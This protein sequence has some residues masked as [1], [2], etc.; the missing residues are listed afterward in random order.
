MKKYII[1]ILIGM[2]MLPGCASAGKAE[3]ADQEDS[4]EAG[5]ADLD[6]QLQ[7]ISDSSKLW[8]VDS[9]YEEYWYAVTDL[10]RDSS[11]EMIA[12]SMQGSGL[13]TWFSIYEVNEDR[14]GL[15]LLPDTL[16]QG[17]SGPDLIVDSA[18]TVEQDGIV[19]YYFEDVLRITAAEHRV[20]KETLSLE[21]DQVVIRPI[22]SFQT[23]PELDENGEPEADSTVEE[24]FDG[25][26]RKI[27]REEFDSLTIIPDGCETIGFG[28]T[29]LSDG[30]SVEALRESF[31]H[32]KLF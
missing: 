15:N 9:E 31:D 24:Y 7:L 20:T 30:I 22:A 25:A 3:E 5:R 10:D 26:N 19:Y 14:T 29:D 13:Y 28:W 17:E 27:S 2:L 21:N 32:F 8:Y 12:A 23:G 1:L 16:E 11:L 18:Q 4:V 6:A